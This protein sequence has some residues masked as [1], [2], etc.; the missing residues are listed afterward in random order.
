MHITRQTRRSDQATSIQALIPT[1]NSVNNR[2]SKHMSNNETLAKLC[3]ITGASGELHGV[4][5]DI[6]GILTLQTST[7]ELQVSLDQFD[8][9]YGG[10]VRCWP[11][12]KPLKDQITIARREAKKAEILQK[13]ADLEAEKA[14]KKADL[15]E[16]ARV[17]AQEKKAK[18]AQRDAKLKA[19]KEAKLQAEKESQVKLQAKA[20]S[21]ASESKQESKPEPKSTP[22]GRRSKK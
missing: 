12:I 13:K 14:K 2:K 15:A 6:K 9:I 22:G 1:V 20:K 5:E 4:G 7:G 19:E 17:K 18:E 8:A 3:A 10:F 21:K 11:T 16:K